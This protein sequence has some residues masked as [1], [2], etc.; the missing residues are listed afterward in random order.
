MISN[1]KY[2]VFAYKKAKVDLVKLPLTPTL[3]ILQ[4]KMVQFI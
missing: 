3:P 4:G 1:P 2:N